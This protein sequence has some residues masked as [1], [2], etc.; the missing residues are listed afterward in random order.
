M[1]TEDRKTFYKELAIDLNIVTEQDLMEAKEAFV[2][3]LN[4]RRPYNEAHIS[5]ALKRQEVDVRTV[6]CYNYRDKSTEIA[7]SKAYLEEQE[8]LISSYLEDYE[9]VL[10]LLSSAISHLTSGKNKDDRQRDA[11]R[12][13]A[14]IVFEKQDIEKL[15]KSVQGRIKRLQTSYDSVSRLVSQW[16]VQL[17]AELGHSVVVNYERSKQEVEKLK[18]IRREESDVEEIEDDVGDCDE[19]DCADTTDIF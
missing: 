5:D 10:G 19:K 11:D 15:L 18:S 13:L 6:E 1:N 4:G 14:E 12:K 9:M 3:Y 16:D 7:E 8:A 2:S 17:K